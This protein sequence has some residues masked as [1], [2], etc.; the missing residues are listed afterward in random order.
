MN[1]AMRIW[2]DT[3]LALRLFDERGRAA[4]RQYQAFVEKRIDT[5]SQVVEVKI[6]IT[7]FQI[8]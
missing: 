5:F 8:E 7:Q 6:Q 1:S 4:N 3:E 2:Q